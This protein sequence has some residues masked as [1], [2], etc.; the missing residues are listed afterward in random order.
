[1]TTTTDLTFT[2]L[3][4]NA[5]VSDW[6]FGRQTC[7]ARFEVETHPKLGQRVAR[8]TENK[9][10]TGWNKPKRTTYAPHFII[11]DGSDERT[12]LLSVHDHL[13]SVCVWPGT[14]K[15]MDYI[16]GDRAFELRARIFA[17]AEGGG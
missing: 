2:N 3:R 4:R 16:Y 14:M 9:T 15:T 1:M 11:A 17:L 13:L 12:Y 10:R 6:P 8:Y 5:E 7:R